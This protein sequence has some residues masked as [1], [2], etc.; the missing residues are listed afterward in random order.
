MSRTRATH[1]LQSDIH[2]LEVWGRQVRQMFNGAM[3]YLVGSALTTKDYRDVDVRLIILDEAEHAALLTALDV[4][5]LN[6]AVSLWGQKA[7]GLP[8]DFQIQS[9]AEANIPGQNAGNRHPLG[10]REWSE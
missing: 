8:I 5:R 3:P 10:M 1:L 6:L 2:L 9:M 4:R 7:T